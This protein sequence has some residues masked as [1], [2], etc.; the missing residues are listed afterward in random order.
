MKINLADSLRN[1]LDDQIANGPL[2]ECE[3][4]LAAGMQLLQQKEQLIAPLVREPFRHGSQKISDTESTIIGNLKSYPTS[5][6]RLAN[7]S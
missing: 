1:Y 3:R 5:Q 2:Q 4:S 7:D 6:A